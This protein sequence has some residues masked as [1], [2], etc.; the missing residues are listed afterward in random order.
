MKLNKLGRWFCFP[1]SKRETL[2]R[3]G[4]A[5]YNNGSFEEA[6]ERFS[7]VLKKIY[8]S[9]C[10]EGRLAS[11]F[12]GMSHCNL[13]VLSI[14]SGDYAR[15]V[16]NLQAAIDFIP[17]QYAPFYYL[18]IAYNNLGQLDEAM[19]A[20]AEV[21]KLNPEFLPV[22]SRVAILFYNE[23]KYSE[24]RS[25]LEKIISQNPMWAD[26][27]F[28]L[29]LVKASQGDHRDG[30]K[31]LET[32]LLIN[33]NYLKARI[34]RGIFLAYLGRA[35][36]GAAIL[37]TVAAERPRF[38]DVVYYLGLIYSA[39]GRIDQSRAAL[40]KAIELNPQ[41]ADAHFCLGMVRLAG[42]FYSES[43]Q[44]FERVLILKPSHAEA[45]LFLKKAEQISS[46]STTSDEREA[47]R[48]LFVQALSV[49]PR[50]QEI[51]P[52]FSDIVDIFSPSTNRGLYLSLVQFYEV[53][54][55]KTPHYADVHDTLG[56]LH[57]KL[58]S[59]DR[60]AVCYRQA[61]KANPRFIRARINLYKL[62]LSRNTPREALIEIDI[63]FDQGLRFPDML[64]DH[65]RI[66]KA[67][68]RP[69]EAIISLRQAADMNATMKPVYILWAQIEEELGHLSQA[70]D[71]IERL[72][73][74]MGD[75][76][77][78]AQYRDWISRL[79][80]KRK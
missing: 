5:C 9:G 51:F 68:G 41:Y 2:Y 25:E 54:A 76:P 30:L 43:R 3:E 19:A 33:P 50:H 47:I 73:S 70:A 29:A 1:K 66:L 55:I 62:L 36:M 23:A 12:S 42:R 61:L 40:E 69:E 21:M 35:E 65:G 52:D 45:R 37:E 27:H 17:E 14:Y 48:K 34:M 49:L 18:G 7:L 8:L 75:T 78:A 79:R 28:H 56:S 15:A 13:G 26:M 22:H 58:G 20:F 32:A 53:T 44:C 24:A 77:A 80:A 39:M 46:E 10:I 11:F 57:A 31:E 72:L 63:L 16:E 71:V 64:L 67:L 4:I 60:A 38:P 6:L 74:N 59:F